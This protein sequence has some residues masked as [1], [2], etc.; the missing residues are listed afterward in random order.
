MGCNCGGARRAAGAGSFE[1][2]VSN[3]GGS[4]TTKYL[5]AS[6]AKAAAKTAGGDA[7]AISA[8]GVRTKIS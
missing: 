7:Y 2:V 1:V 6:E 4:R 5:T 3:S 8:A